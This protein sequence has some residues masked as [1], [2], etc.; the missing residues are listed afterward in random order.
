MAANKFPLDLSK[1]KKIS[2]DKSFTT[3]RHK[4]GHEIKIA[5][6]AVNPKM[7][8]QLQALPAM[9]AEG[10]DVESKDNNFKTEQE[11]PK[12]TPTPNAPINNQRSNTEERSEQRQKF[13]D[14]LGKTFKAEGGKVSENDIVPVDEQGNE[15]NDVVPAD[16]QELPPNDVVPVSSEEEEQR[17]LASQPNMVV[18]MKGPGDAPEVVGAPASSS[19]SSSTAQ[20]ASPMS[21]PSNDLYGAG[22]EQAKASE[23]LRAAAVGQLG[24]QQATALETRNDQAATDLMNTKASLNHINQT[25]DA[26]TKDYQNQHLS[27]NHYLE[28]LNTGQKIATSIGLILGGMGSGLTGQPNAAQQFLNAQI[29]RDLGAQQANMSKQHNLLSALNQQYGNSVVAQNMFRLSRAEMLKNDLDKAAAQSASPM[30]QA[31][32]MKAKAEIDLKYS[33][34]KAAMAAYMGKQSGA[35][36]NSVEDRLQMLRMINPGAAKDLESRYIPGVG[37]GSVPIPDKTRDE[38]VSRESLQQQVAALRKWSQQHSGE[39]KALNPSDVNYGQALSRAVQDAYRRANGQ[40]VFREAEADFVKGIV[41]EDPT[42]FYNKFRVD[43]KFKALE[44]SNEM[45]LNGVK[46]GYG[47]P[48]SDRFT[49]LPPQQQSFVNWARQNPSDPRAKVVIKKYLG[50]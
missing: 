20:P 21:S 9:M 41:S 31:N 2:A 5:H 47:L 36:N 37:V 10:G 26:I 23:D 6:N 1:F 17:Q 42:A 34:L 18:P 14:D 27:P 40:G 25:V 29:E 35:A 32:A 12:P 16:S 11:S 24:Q 8:S 4:D 3:L 15:T 45:A 44:D 43:P 22:I 50:E 48:Q 30:A 13:F 28:S 38:I 39:L 19:S 46:K 7:R 33:P 49:R